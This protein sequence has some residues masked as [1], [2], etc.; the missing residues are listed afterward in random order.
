MTI[1]LEFTRDLYQ[2][3]FNYGDINRVSLRSGDTCGWFLELPNFVQWRQSTVP[4]ALWVTADA[5]CGKSVLAKF[6][7]G[8]LLS[9]N[10]TVIHFFFHHFRYDK[11]SL[12][13]ALLHQL[14]T[15]F[16]PSAQSRSSTMLHMLCNELE[17]KKGEQIMHEDETLWKIICHATTG[18]DLT[19]NK[20]FCVID[21]LDECPRQSRSQFIEL[22]VSVFSSSG[23]ASQRHQPPSFLITSRPYAEIEEH[24]RPLACI[25]L[26]LEN[27]TPAISRDIE[28]MITDKIQ[29]LNPTRFPSRMQRYLQTEIFRKAGRTFLWVKLIFDALEELDSTT[30]EEVR[31]LL[32]TNPSELNYLYESSLSG[33]K[34]NE[35]T[36]KLLQI[37][38]AAT[39]PLSLTEV[40]IAMQIREDCLELSDI[41]LEPDMHGTI[42]RLCGS[43]ICVIDS[44]VDFM[45]QTAREFLVTHQYSPKECEK[46]AIMEPTSSQS[47]PKKPQDLTWRASINVAQSHCVLGSICLRFLDIES[48][49]WHPR[50]DHGTQN[51]RKGAG[52]SS[53]LYRLYETSRQSKILDQKSK[54]PKRPM[55]PARPPPTS[56]HR[57]PS[58]RRYAL[59][60][61]PHHCEETLRTSQEAGFEEYPAFVEVPRLLTI[62]RSSGIDKIRSFIDCETLNDPFVLLE[63]N[64]FH[65]VVDWLLCRL[66][67]H[68]YTNSNLLKAVCKVQQLEKDIIAWPLFQHAIAS[69]EDSEQYSTEQ[70]NKKFSCIANAAALVCSISTIEYLKEKAE[71]TFN[72]D[73]LNAG[74]K[75]A[76]ESSDWSSLA[77][78][79][80]WGAKAYSAGD[81]FRAFT[82]PF[83]DRQ[84]L[85]LLPRAADYRETH[86]TILND[87][88]KMFFRYHPDRQSLAPEQMEILGSFLRFLLDLPLEDYVKVLSEAIRLR[89]PSVVFLIQ[90]RV[91]LVRS[92]ELKQ[93]QNWPWSTRDYY[94]LISLFSIACRYGSPAAYLL[95]DHV[96]PNLDV[97]QEDEF[98]ITPLIAAIL[99]DDYSLCEWLLRKKANVNVGVSFRSDL[100]FPATTEISLTTS[101]MV[102]IPPR[103]W[104]WDDCY[105]NMPGIKSRYGTESFSSCP[106][107]EAFRVRNFRI[108][109]LLLQYEADCWQDHEAEASVLMAA[110]SCSEDSFNQVVGLL[111]ANQSDSFEIDRPEKYSRRTF[112]HIAAKSGFWNSVITLISHGSTVNISDATRSTP[113]HDIASFPPT[114]GRVKIFKKLVEDHNADANITNNTGKTPLDLL[115]ESVSNCPPQRRDQDHFQTWNFLRKLRSE[116]SY[117]PSVRRDAIRAPE[118]ALGKRKCPASSSSPELDVDWTNLSD[119]SDLGSESDSEVSQDAIHDMHGQNHLNS[120]ATG[121]LDSAERTSEDTSVQNEQTGTF[122]FFLRIFIFLCAVHRLACFL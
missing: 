79:I 17:Y 18:S 2:R 98:G 102:P 108:F 21:G 60:N 48:W 104:K 54:R 46:L 37:L 50:R 35:K 109:K 3:S 61:W 13:C 111:R 29:S 62:L 91:D 75:R 58:F 83:P 122:R 32:D 27:E 94:T 103:D 92:C 39:R 70:T 5:G 6:I 65:A 28:K 9:D 88:S 90:S 38:I 87:S 117:L 110:A 42:K 99:A 49:G 85:V 67:I 116:P 113:L 69:F 82:S 51:Y 68:G 31:K 120:D 118:I 93:K 112:L 33:T 24:F 71:I 44:T 14:L 84:I 26:R 40:N 72:Q 4:S 107:M 41:D 74:L 78:L 95:F 15:H 7:I 105:P 16:I 101:D 11:N 80:G 30:K 34:N 63:K 73:I 100:D 19:S 81:V 66:P 47:I 55:R 96:Y 8:Q 12:L 106:L 45:H 53:R 22:V 114:T 43:L 1:L 36:R 76:V 57:Y 64:G 121:S 86:Q 25:R 10:H 77:K 119:N 115:Q 97:N 59:V 23:T 20:L 56:P 89:H 52:P